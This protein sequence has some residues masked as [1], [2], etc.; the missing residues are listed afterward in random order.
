MRSV[1]ICALVGLSTVL[2][3]EYLG[4]CI[5]KNRLKVME[6]LR[7]VKTGEEQRVQSDYVPK[8]RR[9]YEAYS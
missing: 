7:A 2:S 8:F 3:V 6:E 1:G 9:V 4:R 5:C